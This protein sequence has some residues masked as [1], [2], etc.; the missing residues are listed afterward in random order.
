MET[1]LDWGDLYRDNKTGVV[2]KYFAPHEGQAE[3]LNQ[4]DAKFLLALGGVNS[5]KTSMGCLWMALEI[6]A[7]KGKGDYL[8]V[9]PTW[10]VVLS[11]TFKQWEKVING[12]AP[13]AGEWHPHQ[14]NPRYQLESGATIYFRASDANFNGLK[15]KAI[16][17]DEGGDIKEEVF[18][19]LKGRMATGGRILIST[20]PYPKYDWLRFSIMDEADEGN[21]L[22]F[23]KCLP[24]I[25]NPTTDLN[26][27]E[28]ERKKLPPWEFEMRYL[29][30]FTR[31]PN[32]VYDFSNCYVDVPEGGFPKALA[33]FAGVDF[34]GN[35]PTAVVAGFLD[36]SDCL[37]VW[38]EYY[39]T[40]NQDIEKFLEDIKKFNEH[41]KLTTG[42]NITYF[43]DHRPEIINALKRN[44][45]DAR[46]ANKKRIG[47]TGSIEV[48]ISLI[49]SRIR[50]G[51]LKIV[52]GETPNLKMEAGK[53]R[54]PM[55]DGVVVGN[56]PID[57]DN[58]LMD[59]LRYLVSGCDRQELARASKQFAY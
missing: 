13:F 38:W 29:G 1:K 45:I 55:V 46:K 19:K 57:K 35:D 33:Y 4:K 3:I 8:I 2:Q 25:L 11:S 36:E 30:K 12:W 9:A 42:R 21:P 18:N 51:R 16:L 52:K 40:E 41:F 58:H 43:C 49:Q 50:T 56:L 15:P 17:L 44:N 54:Y 32:Q 6:I 27:I 39:A 28:E 22:Y 31:P 14:T 47:R 48:G 59:A 34:G 26:H 24:S 20:T 53:Y 37:W 10:G 7:N 23:Y 5:G